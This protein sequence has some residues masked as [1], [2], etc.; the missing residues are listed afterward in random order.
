M[1]PFK[2]REMLKHHKT[3]EMNKCGGENYLAGTEVKVPPIQGSQIS[4]RSLLAESPQTSLT[5]PSAKNSTWMS[6]EH[7]WNYNDAEKTKLLGE[8]PVPV[9]ICALQISY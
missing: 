9:P 4:R 5:C 6:M 2:Y 7:R 3:E 1:P 8:D